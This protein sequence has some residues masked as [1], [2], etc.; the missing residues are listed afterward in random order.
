MNTTL[1]ALVFG[2]YLGGSGGDEGNA[3]AVDSETSIMVAGQTSS[4]NFPTAG[5]LAISTPSMLTSFLTK[6][7]PNFTLGVS[8]GYLG[9]SIF[10]ADPWHV[11]SYLASTAYGV[12]TDIPIVGDWSGTGTKQIG[13]FRN[14][15]WY[16]DTNNN[17]VLDVADKSIAFGQ[18][19]DIPVVGDWRGTGRIALGLFRQG[20]FILDLSGHLTGVPTGLN[21]ATFVFGQGGDIPIVDDWNGSGTAKAGIFRNVDYC[22]CR[23]YN[24][25]TNRFYTYGQAGDLPV[26]GDWDSSGNP[27]KIGIFRQGLWVL[28]YDGDNTWTTPG[29]TEMVVGFGFAGNNPLVF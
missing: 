14:G 16:L 13:V 20:T 1:S 28:D 19:G 12:S 23:V 8:Y 24:S 3:I 2:T 18:A 26:V 10:V 11:S 6:I 22:G 21:D 27:P 5:N 7:A 17:G 29:L 25:S 4:R 15:T 9:Q